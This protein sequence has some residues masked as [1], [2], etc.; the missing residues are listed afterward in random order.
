MQY[1]KDG[2]T[3]PVPFNLIPV[4]ASIFRRIKILFKKLKEK[5][6]ASSSN[7]SQQ[8]QQQLPQLQ[9]VE[10]NAKYNEEIQVDCANGNEANL[11]SIKEDEKSNRTN[12]RIYSVENQ[13]LTYRVSLL[14]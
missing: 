12:E 10:K 1:I 9:S 8:Q 11:K 4:P 6:S 5:Q 3:L 14:L 2:F 13:K 7:L